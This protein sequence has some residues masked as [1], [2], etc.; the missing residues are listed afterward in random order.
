MH[1]VGG[2]IRD[3]LRGINS[4]DRDFIIR[5]NRES[6]VRDLKKIL[7][8]KAIQFK[9]GNTIRIAV[10][11]EI[12][13]DFSDMAG[14]LFEDLSKR[15]FTINAMAWSPEDGLIDFFHGVN[16]LNKHIV[17]AISKE[18]MLADPLR[19][20]RT[21]RFAAEIK[22][23]IEIKTR[24]MVKMFSHTIKGISSERITLEMF[25]L[26][27]SEH[28][29][30]YLKLALTDGLLNNI[31]LIT[32]KELHSNI[33]SIA[34]REKGIFDDLPKKIKVRLNKLFSQNL[35]YKGLL[36]L[37]IL[38]KSGTKVDNFHPLIKLSN[39]IKR[40]IQLVHKALERFSVE[41][42]DLFSIFLIA[43]EASIDALIISNR[44]DLLREYHRFR[45]IWKGGFLSSEAIKQISGIEEGA[46]LGEIILKVKREEYE[47]NIRTKAQAIRYLTSATIP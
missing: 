1:L 2:Y 28:A 21:Y 42:P 12:T 15:D 6:F 10:K 44:V 38:I 35:T 23:K 4:R 27:N 20:L 17:R 45:R 39:M 40:R 14:T 37:E 5:N 41:N 13:F 3:L 24:N 16:D 19:I 34:Q 25:H 11:K 22:G 43:Q 47:G 18:N 33:K 36:C 46:R 31:L 9:R 26:L 32:Y 30:K 8:G 29:S 7:G